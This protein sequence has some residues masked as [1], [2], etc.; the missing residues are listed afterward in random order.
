MNFC[1]QMHQ[2]ITMLCRAAA[3]AGVS[4]NN[5]SSNNGREANYL[6]LSAFDTFDKEDQQ[7]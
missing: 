4:H 6:D 5:S 2:L 3:A 7:S 1:K